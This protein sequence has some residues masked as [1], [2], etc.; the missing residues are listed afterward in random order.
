MCSLPDCHVA[1]QPPE[2]ESS[3]PCAD[4]ELR[5][6][7]TER[8]SA[9]DIDYFEKFTLVDV[10]GPGEQAVEDR[11]MGQLAAKVATEEPKPAKEAAE[12][13]LPA[14]EDSFVIVSDVDIVGE[15][16]DEVFYGEGA[17]ADAL[18]QR[19]F[20]AA[21]GAGMRSRRESQRSAKESGSVLFETEE[22]TLTPIYI[23]PGPP[24]IIDPILLEEP[25]AMSFMYSDLYEDAV[26]ERRKSDEEH[27]ESESVASE[28]ASKRRL[29]DSEEADG[30]LEKFI[31]KDETPTVEVPPETVEE[32]REGRMMWAQNKFEMTG[33]LARVPK[34]EDEPRRKME[35]TK[36]QDITVRDREEDPRA[37]VVDEWAEQTTEKID[38][39]SR[40]EKSIQESIVGD[41][42]VK[43]KVRKDQT[44][45]SESSTG[46]APLTT[47][48][49]S[50]KDDQREEL[51]ASIHSNLL[52]QTQEIT[53]QDVIKGTEEGIGAETG[54]AAAGAEAVVTTQSLR[55]A[56]QEPAADAATEHSAESSPPEGEEA[57]AFDNGEV[58]SECGARTRDLVEVNDKPVSKGEIQSEVHADLQ[59]AGNTEGTGDQ[60][61]GEI[62][63]AQSLGQE[64][65]MEVEREPEGH[66]QS[67]ASKPAMSEEAGR[68]SERNLCESKPRPEEESA[69]AGAPTAQ[70]TLTPEG[71]KEKTTD[72]GGRSVQKKKAA[73]DFV[74]LVPKGQAVE[75]DIEISHVPEVTTDHSKCRDLTPPCVTMDTEI[76]ELPDDGTEPQLEVKPNDGQEEKSR[77]SPPAP[78]EDSVTDQEK[79][80]QEPYE[81][82]S[83]ALRSFTPQEDLSGL[84]GEDTEAR[85][86]GE[87]VE[88]SEVGDI[89]EGAVDEERPSPETKEGKMEPEEVA[90]ESPDVN[91]EELDYEVIGEQEAKEM[92]EEEPQRDAERPEPE[93]EP[94]P[95]KGSF[96][97]SPEEEHIED[98][99][100]IFDAEEERQA[101]LAAELQGLDWFCFTCGDLLSKDAHTSEEHRNHYVTDVDAAYEEIKVKLHVLRCQ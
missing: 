8:D 24:K 60:T 3:Q 89:T 37:A 4:T 62:C 38:K 90:A 63:D 26:G 47:Q 78:T 99:Y 28:K 34:D 41:E 53:E 98:D 35:E 84:L 22:T 27:S 45:N 51:A 87:E 100:E 58:P 10:V 91:V 11:E 25:T 68:C 75:M 30:Y 61:A 17:P 83:P 16:L 44:E 9:N 33:Y 95:Q 50:C 18:Q 82:V 72:D 23:S 64:I 21:C 5:R 77:F 65:L 71:K 81:G 40:R 76:P 55:T 42:T 57:A 2:L 14:S 46:Q 86:E 54:E 29:S 59:E 88:T 39:E 101:R 93:P 74:L 96:D 52:P 31:L 43:C 32:G 48:A 12:D 73:E 36:E 6:A 79:V 70:T 66:G 69:T 92:C 13:S 19:E 20:E 49:I 85:H 94:E 67:A 56:G 7:L 15:H 1:S 80:E 97:L